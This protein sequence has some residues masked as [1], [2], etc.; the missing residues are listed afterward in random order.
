MTMTMQTVWH[1]NR[2]GDVGDLERDT[3][4]LFDYALW[5]LLEWKP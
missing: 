2:W 5:A 3:P 1:R 4:D